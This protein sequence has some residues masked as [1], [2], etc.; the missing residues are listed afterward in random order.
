MGKEGQ[1]FTYSLLFLR[2]C[3]RDITKSRYYWVVRGKLLILAIDILVLLIEIRRG[4]ALTGEKLFFTP[5]IIGILAAIIGAILH[6]T[7]HKRR[8]RIF[9][10]LWRKK[11]HA[12]EETKN[13]SHR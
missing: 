5:V 11:E 10:A 12:C 13:T 3:W 9:M 4:S 1:F 8:I 6:S 2:E 7:R